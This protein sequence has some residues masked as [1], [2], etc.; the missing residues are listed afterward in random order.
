MQVC[1]IMLVFLHTH[2]ADS[3]KYNLKQNHPTSGTMYEGEN[4]ANN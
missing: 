2:V 4:L 3:M 1:E